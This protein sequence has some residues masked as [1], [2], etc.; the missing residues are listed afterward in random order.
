MENREQIRAAIADHVKRIKEIHDKFEKGRK[1]N[2]EEL[3]FIGL[4]KKGAGR[5]AKG[6]QELP[7]YGSMGACASATGIPL[8]VIKQAKSDG[9]EAFRFSRIQL[10]KLLPFIF[11]DRKESNQATGEAAVNWRRE[12]EKYK[13]KRE[14]RA[15]ERDM[16]V[17]VSKDDVRR[18]IVAGMAEVYQT[19]DRVFCNELPPTLIGLDEM[20]IRN[21]VKKEIDQMKIQLRQ[22]FA[23]MTDVQP[24]EEADDGSVV[25]SFASS[26]DSES[27]SSESEPFDGSEEKEA[28]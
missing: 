13:A 1:L 9:C 26:F 20:Q 17:L 21:R 11:R 25:Q 22:R 12:W 18:D 14:K 7:V 4:D 23:E 15:Y 24:V 3:E 5:P 19:L 10:G 28:A 27:D 16:G 2:A 6:S 8:F